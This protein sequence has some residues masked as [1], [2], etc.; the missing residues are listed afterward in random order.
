MIKDNFING[1]TM[2]AETMKRFIEKIIILYT[3]IKINKPNISM[4]SDREIEIVRL[5]GKGLESKVIAKALNLRISTIETHRRNIRKKL[6]LKGNG[7]LLQ[8]AIVYN[9]MNP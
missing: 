7:K 6:N 1:R 9:L 3:Q 2:G 5:V 4:L 8:F